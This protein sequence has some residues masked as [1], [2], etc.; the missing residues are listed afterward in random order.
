MG[1]LRTTNKRR[2]RAIVQVQ[3]RKAAVA[4]PAAV[5]KTT[6]VAR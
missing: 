6:K 3:T 1:Q 2:K 4:E 5:K